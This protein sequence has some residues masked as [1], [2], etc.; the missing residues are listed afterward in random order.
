MTRPDSQAY[1][2]VR[3]DMTAPYARS[4]NAIMAA[5]NDGLWAHLSATRGSVRE[6]ELGTVGVVVER[7]VVV[8]VQ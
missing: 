8:H 1:R 6:R 2:H 3:S 4:A 5:R 7:R